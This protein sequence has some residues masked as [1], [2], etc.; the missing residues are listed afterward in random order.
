MI[1]NSPSLTRFPATQAI[2][3]AT[4]SAGTKSIGQPGSNGIIGTMPANR[5]AAT[6]CRPWNAAISPVTESPM[7]T[8]GRRI[9]CGTPLDRTTCSAASFD[10]A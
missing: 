10:A 7:T 5:P 2:A 1:Q 6:W 3:S 9:T 4:T 8:D